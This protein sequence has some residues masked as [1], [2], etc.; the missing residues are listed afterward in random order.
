MI[1]FYDAMGPSQGIAALSDVVDALDFWQDGATV[2]V[3]DI[4][5]SSTN[6]MIYAVAQTA[7][8]TGTVE[9]VWGSTADVTITDNTVTWLVKDIR[10]ADAAKS[11]AKWTAPIKINGIDVDG[12]HDITLPT[13]TIDGGS[14]IGSGL[15]VSSFDGLNVNISSG[16]AKIAGSG[17][18]F[19]GGQLALN[20]RKASLMYLDSAGTLGK[21]DCANPLDFVDD[22]TVA[23]WIFNQT[24]AGANIP[25]AAV[26]KSAIAVANDLIPHGGITSVDGWADTALQ[27]DGTTGYFI[28]SNST[29]IPSGSAEREVIT[30]FT[31]NAIGTAGG[32]IY[33]TGGTAGSNAFRIFHTET[34]EIKVT[35]YASNITTGYTASIGRTY[36]LKVAYDGTNVIVSINGALL[37]KF[38]LAISN[39]ETV[40]TIGK[41]VGGGAFTSITLHYIEVRNKMRSDVKT[42]EISNKLIMPCFYDKSSAVYPT[43]PTAYAAA[44]HEYRFDETSGTAVADSNTTMPMAG[45]ATG[46]TV[47]DSDLGLGKARK[48]NGTAS[49]YLSLGNFAMGPQFTYIGV[50]NISSYANYAILWQNYGGST[51]RN[52][53]Y[54]DAG[55]GKLRIGN[56]S[57]WVEISDDIIPLNTNVFIAVVIKGME[58]TAYFNKVNS[59]K[60]ATS[61]YTPFYTSY[62]VDIGRDR[63]VGYFAGTYEYLAFGNFELTQSEIAQM[64]NS[65]MVKGRRNILN[66]LLP[67]GTVSLGFVRTGSSKI[68]EYNDTDYKYGR[69]EGATGG[70][71]KVFLGWKYFNG[72]AVIKWDNPFGTGKAK[73]TF[74]WAQGSTGMNELPA[75]SR[76]N[77]GANNMYGVQPT[78]N[79]FPAYNDA[80]NITAMVG[81]QGA[82]TFNGVWQT[83]GYLGC[84]I[85]CLEDYKGA[86]AV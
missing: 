2:K 16:R 85:E 72:N 3:G 77:D 76:F 44:C 39:V 14:Y 70:N 40:P 45:T 49:D 69:R 43:M 5:R 18:A 36:L 24:T 13:D 25:N 19:P 66:D 56:G 6:S 22:N 7:G 75:C 41:Y 74:A 59:P 33:D 79:N 4:A 32:I 51:T 17:I 35:N 67:T 71:R 15:K 30:L 28:G 80:Q 61:A 63:A 46:T 21:V 78:S 9:P 10:T 8:V 62:P 23:M 48:F 81:A 42:A 54:I 47:V 1:K 82:T 57:T 68:L 37:G 27:L 11:A 53:I 20:P 55:T 83:S 26:G 29:G 86:D 84:Y 64:Y 34:G 58:I 38:P 65:L 12:S 31:L 73:R 52:C 60:K 50:V